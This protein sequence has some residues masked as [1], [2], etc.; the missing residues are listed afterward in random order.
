MSI[1][2]SYSYQHQKVVNY[3]YYFQVYLGLL[4]Y[5]SLPFSKLSLWQLANLPRAQAIY[6]LLTEKTQR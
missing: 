6:Q 3:P 2:I 4:P 5:L 1:G